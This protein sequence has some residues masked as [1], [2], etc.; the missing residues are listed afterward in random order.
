M[1]NPRDIISDNFQVFISYLI[2]RLYSVKGWDGDLWFK[3]ENVIVVFGNMQVQRDCFNTKSLSEILW[4]G[5]LN[6]VFVRRET[7]R[8]SAKFFQACVPEL[9]PKAGISKNIF[10]YIF[11]TTSWT[12]VSNNYFVQLLFQ[13]LFRITLRQNLLPTL[14]P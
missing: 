1:N 13:R 2:V 14:I 4:R 7:K 10:R 5:K 12:Y 3:P 8:I 11:L 6:R 9:K